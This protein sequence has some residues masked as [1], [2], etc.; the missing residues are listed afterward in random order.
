MAEGDLTTFLLAE[1]DL[2]PF[3]VPAG[4]E[5]ILELGPLPPGRYVVDVLHRSTRI[6]PQRL[7]ICRRGAFV[8][9]RQPLAWRSNSVPR[10]RRSMLRGG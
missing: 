5:W 6:G 7:P 9:S 4:K 3:P 2:R 10:G 8:G 1:D